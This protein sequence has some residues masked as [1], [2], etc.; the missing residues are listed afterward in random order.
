NE[1]N[2]GI[3]LSPG[4]GFFI[5]PNTVVYAKGIG[6]LGVI[7]TT[8]EVALPAGGNGGGEKGEKGEKGDIGPMGPKGDQ[9]LQG[10]K[11]EKGDDGDKGDKGDNGDNG[12][13]IEQNE[14]TAIKIWIGTQDE[15]NNIQFPDETTLYMIKGTH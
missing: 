3:T 5:K 2:D 14:K 10:P 11:G 9:G 13:L 4:H 12:I 7:T 6:Q 1:I 15:Y 8:T